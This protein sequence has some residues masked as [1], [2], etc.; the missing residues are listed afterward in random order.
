MQGFVDTLGKWQKW[1]L[2]LRAEEPY[3][4]RHG[5][6]F[7]RLTADLILVDLSTSQETFLRYSTH[8]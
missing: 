7:G 8:L 1:P 4:Q 6:Y 3:A 5:C 2:W